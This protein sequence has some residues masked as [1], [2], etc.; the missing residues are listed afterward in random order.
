MV[1]VVTLEIQE[2][3]EIKE[4]LVLEVMVEVVMV[5]VVEMQLLDQL[6]VVEVDK[7]V[8]VEEMVALKH[9]RQ[10][11]L[12]PRVQEEILVAGLEADQEILEIE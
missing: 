6:A 3:Q 7:E 5:E 12:A 8:Q 10:A 11:S 4:T 2:I 9:Q 1:E